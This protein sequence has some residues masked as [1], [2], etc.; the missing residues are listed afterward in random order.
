M[1]KFSVLLAY[2]VPCYH[3]V[4]IDAENEDDADRKAEKILSDFDDLNVFEPEWSE[5]DDFRVVNVVERDYV[6]NEPG[7]EG[8]A[9]L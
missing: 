4:V 8:K 6:T 2:D 9:S 7:E 5:M 3:T 1:R